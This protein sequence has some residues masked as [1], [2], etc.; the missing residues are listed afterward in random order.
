MNNRNYVIDVAYDEL[1]YTE[2]ASNKDL[3]DKYKNAGNNN[4]TKYGRDM[5]ACIGE[6][7]ANGCAWCDTFVDWCFVKAYGVAEAHKLLC[8]W[9]A[10]TPTSAS[11]YKHHKQYSS[12]PEIGAQ[13]FF[14]NSYGVICHTGIVVHLD[15]DYVYTIEGNTNKQNG[16]SDNGGMV[17]YKKYRRDYSRID[18]YGIPKYDQDEITDIIDS[19]YDKGGVIT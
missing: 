15:Q 6:P 14:T 13:I 12:T 1:G 4:Y 17:C 3:D 7:Y 11:F 19:L 2:K 8:G 18:G 5:V 16:V 9:S 10:Y